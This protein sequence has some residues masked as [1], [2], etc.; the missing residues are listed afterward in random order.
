MNL[1]PS[2]KYQVFFSLK[3][4]EKIFKIG[5]CCSCDWCLKGLSNFES[6][7]TLNLNYKDY[8]V[9]KNRIYYADNKTVIL[10]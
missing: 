8:T 1:L 5:I 7:S 2:M 10:L 4:N 6:S 3:N 9:Y